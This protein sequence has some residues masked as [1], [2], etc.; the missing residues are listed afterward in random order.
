MAREHSAS[1]RP[2]RVVLHALVIAEGK[3]R[4]APYLPVRLIEVISVELVLVEQPPAASAKVTVV[5]SAID[6]HDLPLEIWDR[7]KALVPPSPAF[8]TPHTARRYAVW[9]RARKSLRL[10]G[11]STVA[12]LC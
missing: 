1:V 6:T 12:S 4:H 7:I 5:T 10:F 3:A 8:G 2:R 11:G 9:L